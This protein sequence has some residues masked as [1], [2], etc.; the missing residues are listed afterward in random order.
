VF[1]SVIVFIF[2]IFFISGILFSSI[3]TLC[4]VLALRLWRI[5]FIIAAALA[6]ANAAAMM[7]LIRHKRSAST[8]Q[9]VNILEN[10][11][12]EIKKIQKMKTITDKNTQ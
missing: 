4:V 12:P 1:L 10:K 11:I 7:K 5:S 6:Y 9:S 8:T 2:C 3:F